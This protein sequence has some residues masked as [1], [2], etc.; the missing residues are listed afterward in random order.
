MTALPANFPHPKLLGP[1]A[2]GQSD[3]K[4]L[5]AADVSCQPG[6]ALLATASNA[7]QE[8]VALRDPKDAADSTP[9]ERE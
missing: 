9:G 2:F 1:I 8:G 6:Q 5:Q 4:D 7:N 3:L